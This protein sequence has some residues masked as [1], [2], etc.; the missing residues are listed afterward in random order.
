MK[1]YVYDHCPYCVKARMIF[2][3]KDLT[4]EMVTLLNDDE[5]TPVSMIGQKMVPILQK[6]DGSF[7][8][9][10]MDIVRY[11]EAHYGVKKL[12]G[13]SNPALADWLAGSRDYLYSLCFPRW[14]KTPLEEFATEGARAYFTKKKEAS[15]GPFPEA[16]RRSEALIHQAQAHLTALEPLIASKDAVNGELSEDDIHLFAML[17]SLSI[18]RGVEYPSAVDAYRHRMAERSAIPLHDGVAI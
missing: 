11:I 6:Q 13:G 2:G 1:L 8:P 12:V 4:F 18:V 9:E 17:R 7:M 3:F 5:A 16:T 14:V 15:I 10:S